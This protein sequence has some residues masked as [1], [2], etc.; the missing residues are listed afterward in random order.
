VSC[1]PVRYRRRALLRPVA[2]APLL[3][4]TP[5]A[6]RRRAAGLRLLSPRDRLECAERLGVLCLPARPRRGYDRHGYRENTHRIRARGALPAADN[7]VPPDRR[8]D[9]GLSCE[10]RL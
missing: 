8:R 1:L 9:L 6:I 5:A 3:A 10:G 2:A 7:D 4:G